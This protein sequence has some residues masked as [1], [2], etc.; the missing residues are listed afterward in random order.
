MASLNARGFSVCRGCNSS[1]LMDILDLGKSPVANSLPLIEQEISE[2]EYPLMLK[3]CLACSLGQIGEFETPDEIFSIYPY[4]SSTS[5]TWIEHGRRFTE[6]MVQDFP[7]LSE[8]Y[9]LEVASNDGY[10]L[11]HFRERLIDVLGVEP[12]S[13]VAEMAL[14]NGIP[15][16]SQF[17]GLN[18]ANEIL[19]LKGSPSLIIANNVAAHVPDMF[20][21]FS[22]LFSL[23][24]SNTVVTIE[25][26]SL[27]YMLENGFYDTIYHEHFS[28]LSVNSVRILAE[29]V[30]LDLF[31]VDDLNTHGGSLRYFL[32][33]KGSRE[34]EDSVELNYIQE[35]S[36]GVENHS[37]YT[38]FANIVEKSMAELNAWV[39]SQKDGSIIGFG[40]AAKTVTTFH[41]A[42]LDQRKFSCI[43][44][45]NPIKQGRRLPGTHIPITSVGSI[46]EGSPLILIFPWNISEEITSYIRDVNPNAS[47]WVHNPLRELN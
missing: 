46:S 3:I 47:V 36:R 43:V 40:A 29:K 19:G 45:S 13:N 2:L 28:Y 31:R 24:S 1:E 23:C 12:A 15:T 20:D 8:S 6:M 22:G 42:A 30:G 10:L 5:T 14:E 38:E 34:I 33:I 11:Q 35:L 27:G 4:L 16:I 26:P 32:C 17:F 41:A 44:D 7:G 39:S 18:L 25:N 9:V 37:K 21:F